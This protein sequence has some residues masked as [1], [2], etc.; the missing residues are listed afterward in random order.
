MGKIKYSLEETQYIV[1][2]YGYNL[3]SIEDNKLNLIDN[4]GYEY[5][6]N[7]YTFIH[8]HNPEKFHK[9]NPYTIQNIKLWCK[10]NN[11]LFELISDI[12]EG[13]KKLL[14]WKCLKEDCL[15]EFE[16]NWNNIYTGNGCGFCNGKQVSKSNCLA[17]K[18]SVLAKEWHPTK[19]VDLTPYD[20]TANSNKKVWWQCSKNPKHVW[21]AIIN[22]RVKGNECPYCSGR[23]PS[24]E[25]NLLIVNPELCEDWNYNKNKKKPEEY[26]PSTI[27][28][29]W[30][31]CKE[32]D[33]EW[34]ATINNRNNGTG[35]PQCNE[36]KG[37]KKISQYLIKDII[38]YLSQ[39]TFDGLVGVGGGLLSYDFYIPKLNLL[40]EYQ[41]E[42]HERYIPGFHKSKKDF[43][44]QKE[45]DRRKKEYAEQ[46]GYNFLEIWYWD[47]DNIEEIL[48]NE[49]NIL[50]K[51][52]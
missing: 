23:Y 11:K 15:E 19:N 18:N 3:I 44:K 52:S 48:E 25:Y 20:V 50:A 45:H 12:Y 32:C 42:Q 29:V 5:L 36:S 30:W 2:K 17:T 6:I 4:E 31:K 43:L 9:T 10:S 7:I 22:N 21:K 49:L 1:N 24:E 27:K 41:G 8:K 35:C 46:N 16:N 37:E 26:T 13:N 39:K 34:E 28:K 33:H 40:I 14:K 38:F 51:A 47:F